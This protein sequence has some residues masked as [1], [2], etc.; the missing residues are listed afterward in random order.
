MR[1]LLIFNFLLNK[2]ILFYF[3]GMTVFYFIWFCLIIFSCLIKLICG[4]SFFLWL[5]FLIK[6]ILIWLL[7]ISLWVWV[8]SFLLLQFLIYSST[9]PYQLS[10]FLNRSLRLLLLLELCLWWC[11]QITSI[12]ISHSDWFLSIWIIILT[13]EPLY[14]FWTVNILI[15]LLFYCFFKI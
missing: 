8:I 14:L 9:I 12:N 6:T 3:R 1:F 2:F 10:L 5:L 7:K 11:C 13:L 4:V 15:D